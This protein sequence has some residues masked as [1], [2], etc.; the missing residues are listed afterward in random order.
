[1]QLLLLLVLWQMCDSQ[2]CR[3][4]TKR[5][6]VAA[7]AAGSWQLCN[8]RTLAVAQL[9]SSSSSSSIIVRR[10]QQQQQVVRVAEGSGPRWHVGSS[11]LLL[12]VMTTTAK[13]QT[14]VTLLLL[15]LVRVLQQQQQHSAPA[16][17][18]AAELLAVAWKRES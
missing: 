11:R 13:H 9:P 16:A 15:V 8:V 14:E 18:A 10:Q 2:S 5:L 12:C 6:A 17:A 4:D 1:V 7:A 3:A